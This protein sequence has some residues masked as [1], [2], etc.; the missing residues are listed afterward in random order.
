VGKV[1][2]D[3]LQLS[4]EKRYTQGLVMVLAYTWSK[5]LE[6]VG[7]LNNQDAST[8]KNLTAS[9]RPHRL[10]LSGVYELPFGRG[11]AF[12]SDIGRGWNMLV[13]GWE[14]NFIGIMQSGT[15]VDLSGNADVIGN[16]SDEGGT[17]NRWFNN[18]V[19]PATGSASCTDPA[20]R[21]RGPNTLRTTPFRAGWIRNPSR[22]LWDMSLNKR[23]AFSE[24][25]DLQFRFET[26]NVFNSPVRPGPVTDPTRAD[27]GLI[28]LG[29]S[30][31]PR[32]VQL[33]FKFNF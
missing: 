11:K 19:A 27:F 28:P 10:V 21:L 16:I 18:C 22:P 29:Q 25:T 1:W 24:R 5:N 8:T 4:V 17:F 20:W 30:N 2:Y 9:D 33:G 6:S 31:I 13:G 7:F 14:Y 3:A 23:I 12:G 32:Q 26:F 15:P